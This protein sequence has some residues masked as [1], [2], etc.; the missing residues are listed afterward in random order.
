MIYLI[1]HLLHH[2]QLVVYLYLLFVGQTGIGHKHLGSLLVVGHQV[3]TSE[4][5][6]VL[7]QSAQ[8]LLNILDAFVNKLGRDVGSILLVVHPSLLIHVYQCAD[9]QF[10]A[11]GYLVAIAYVDDA[12]L[13]VG[14]VD[15]QLLHAALYLI[16]FLFFGNA[17]GHFALLVHHLFKVFG[18]DYADGTHRCLAYGIYLAFYL[19]AQLFLVL[20]HLV[21][22]KCAVLSQVHLQVGAVFICQLGE[23]ELYWQRFLPK[24]A[25]HQPVV[26]GIAC[27]Q[28]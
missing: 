5:S 13:I 11:L 3:A 28:T 22:R 9:N 27:V 17:D 4:L 6:D 14:Q 21:K 16:V 2:I 23:G 26:S 25:F 12:G 19:A 15:I 10:G 24:V 20:T 1:T 7:I 8:L 18:G